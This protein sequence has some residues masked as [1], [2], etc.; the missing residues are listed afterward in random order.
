VRI[1]QKWVPVLRLECAQ[2]VNL[3]RF[4]RRTATH[5]AGKR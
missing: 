5:F 1:P 3:T 4:L 2:A